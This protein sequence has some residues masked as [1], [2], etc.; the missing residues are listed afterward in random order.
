MSESITIDSV[1][2]NF[3]QQEVLK[4]IHLNFAAG[5]VT[6]ILG[7]NGCGKSCLLKIITGQLR[8]QSSHI[9]YQERKL[10]NLY[11]VPRLINYAPQHEFHPQS[12]R[13]NQLLAFYDIDQAAF[14]AQYPF[15][16]EK[17]DDRF[18]T[19][20]G[21]ERRLVEVLL[22]LES[23]TKFSILDEPFTHVMPKHVELL[24]ERILALKEKKG[25]L[26]TDHQYEN[27]MEISDRMYL[28]AEGVARE[29]KGTEGLRSYGYLR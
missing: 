13:L 17:I 16:A 28:I 24:Q 19:L 11:K 29:V 22:V 7:R 18:Y 3:G 20:S 12:L 15:L 10:E 23:D 8:A 25:I 2:L 21:G 27:V 26:I 14:L 1:F 4:G 5:Q 6:G 9:R